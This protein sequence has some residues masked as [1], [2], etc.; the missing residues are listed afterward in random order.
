M[1]SYNKLTDLKSHTRKIGTSNDSRYKW[2]LPGFEPGPAAYE[3]DDIPNSLDMWKTE[4]QSGI[5]NR[6]LRFYFY[7]E[8]F[9]QKKEDNFL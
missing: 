1:K 5:L 2:F 6:Y 3:A 9:F 8:D 4:Q 7:F